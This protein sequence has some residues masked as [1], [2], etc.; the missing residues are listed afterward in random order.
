M[1]D[2]KRPDLRVLTDW[3]CSVST[4][5]RGASLMDMGQ[6]LL[7]A[8]DLSVSG[9]HLSKALGEFVRLEDPLDRQPHQIVLSFLR[10][11]VLFRY[12][13]NEDERRAFLEY[14]LDRHN[15][16]RLDVVSRAYL[17]G[18]ALE[19]LHL[20]PDGRT[21]Y[22]A[23]WFARKSLRADR[24]RGWAPHYLRLAG[25][26]KEARDRAESL[27]TEREANG[28]WRGGYDATLGI[29]YALMYSGLVPMRAL[30]PTI[31]YVARRFDGK[32]TGN[33]GTDALALKSLY[34][35]G[36][37]SSHCQ[38]AIVTNLKRASGVFLSHSS[39]D[40]QF[41]RKLASDLR[42][43]GV[44]LDEEEIKVGESIIA[45]VQE[46]LANCAHIVVVL[47]KHSVRSRWVEKELN[48]A[49]IG[50]LSG[51]GARVF[52]VL[53]EDCEVPHLLRELRYADFRDAYEHGLR[54]L[55]RGLER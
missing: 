33:H 6:V 12:D 54:E 48:T 14:W 41:V 21:E 51:S 50:D 44:W 49:L 23:H 20:V 31:D 27:L 55:L 8:R 39:Q 16:Q 43:W 13:R 42:P 32:S 2:V 28:S 40:K 47:S 53:I 46:A 3:F 38:D 30:A 29:M 4:S 5:N 7:C 9:Y 17:I 52:P 36:L 35:A 11:I 15:I 37:L 1:G 45:R 18:M 22:I 34:R 25:M 24:V 26:E 10:Q 19:Q